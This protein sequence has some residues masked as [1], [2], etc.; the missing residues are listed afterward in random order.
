MTAHLP[1]VLY[2]MVSPRSTNCCLLDDTK[3]GTVT[4]S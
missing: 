4:G 1:T 3:I 2:D